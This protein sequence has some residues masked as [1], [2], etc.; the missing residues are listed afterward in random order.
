LQSP[1]LEV[2]IKHASLEELFAEIEMNVEKCDTKSAT[3][4][5]RVLQGF[6]PLTNLLSLPEQI[7]RIAT[8]IYKM[9]QSN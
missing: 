7:V 2:P 3:D 9:L 1:R 5:E 4:T 8:A 6:R